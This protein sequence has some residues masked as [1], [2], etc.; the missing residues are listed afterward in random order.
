RLCA[1]V[2][3][4]SA[5]R[6]STAQSGDFVVLLGAGGGLGHI[7]TQMGSRGMG[8]RIIG[9]DHGSKKD[10]VLESGAEHFIDHTTSKDVKADV[11][12]LTGGLGAQAV[13][14]LTAANG[15]YASGMQLLKFGVMV[16]KEQKVVGSAVGNR[17]E[18][19]ETLDLAARGIIK[20]H[21][22]TAKMEKL[23]GIFEEMHQGKIQGRVVLDLQ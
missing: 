10:L 14:V 1:G 5:F 18:A 2:T 13:L 23:T 12:A 16:A 17:K 3:V 19:I 15:A 9:I 6:K 8:M 7:A 4:Y 22:R 11:E 21:F 20:T